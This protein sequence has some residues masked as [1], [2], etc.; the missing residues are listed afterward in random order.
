MPLASFGYAD[1]LAAF[2]EAP[3][4]SLVGAL[5]NQA[6]QR[7]LTGA[8]DNQQIAAWRE[9]LTWL[10]NAG[11][12]LLAEH[13][14][15]SGWTVCLEYEIPRRSGRIDAVLLA[16]DLIFV[17]EFKS[18]RVDSQAR[19]QAE[20]YALELFDFHQASQTRRLFPIACGARSRQEIAPLD[21]GT[22]V[23]ACSTCPPAGLAATILAA[24][25]THHQAERALLDHEA[26]LGSPYHPTPTIIEAARALYAGHAIREL[27]QSEASAEHLR[28]TQE[29]VEA[30]VREARARRRRAI[31]FLTGIPGAG[32]TLAGL[33]VVHGLDANL[34]A[35]FL[36]GN[37]P[38]VQVLQA[39]LAQDLSRREGL[40]QSDAKRRA[41]TLVTNVHRWIDEYVDKKPY[42]LPHE[43]V[44]VFDEAQRAWSREQSKRK[45]GRDA[46]EP[47]AMLEVMSRRDTAVVVGLVGGGQE[48][49][50]GEAGLS[51]W[52]RALASRFTD[53]DIV[54]SPT[55]T[56]GELQAGST[57]F[58]R[59]EDVPEERLT[60]HPD[61]HLA[62]TQRS[63]RA[64]QL[65]EWVELVLAGQADEA[66]RLM[67]E[68]QRYP[69]VMTRDLARARD[70]LRERN[71]G[72]RRCGLLASSGARRLRQDGVTV[73]E[74][75]SAVDWFLKP[76][77]DVRS[78]SFLEL[79]M[80]EFG[81]QGL[82]VDWACVAWGGDLTRDREGWLIRDFKGTRWQ[83]VRKTERRAYAINR[84]RVLLT[85]AREGMVI[86]VPRGN[87]EDE[88]RD[89]ARQQSV[90]EYLARCGLKSV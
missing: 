79:P 63:F 49:N 48:I 31:C 28:R 7:R 24:H 59:A 9:S 81:V 61:L 75:H 85:R 11:R 19:R 30:V 41:T 26:W 65:S 10:A 87:P 13:P 64:E 20:D 52:G 5:T 54:V 46:S 88:T 70:W 33:N 67:E 76:A 43:D 16:D 18:T 38:L 73:R 25:A 55:M 60:T 37:G 32:K 1:S 34:K 68:L 14:A 78:S 4:D 35:T 6:A 12:E 36:S 45:F 2:V 50:T 3:L 29:A 51:E 44:V 84:Y 40:T 82:E 53:W 21:A 42:E 17:L 72:L 80:T 22:G 66:S 8:V 39:V 77:D 23:A 27:S 69:M 90:W 57:L 83:E 62:V 71:R 89:P 15:A 47:E 74:Q 58:P 86:W 56:S